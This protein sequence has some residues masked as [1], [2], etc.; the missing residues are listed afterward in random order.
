M[1]INGGAKSA[2]FSFRDSNVPFD[3]G[4]QAEFMLC[5]PQKKG[6]L[7]SPQEAK[8]ADRRMFFAKS[9]SSCSG[10][11][12]NQVQQ[13]SGPRSALLPRHS[14]RSDGKGTRSSSFLALRSRRT[15]S[16]SVLPVRARA[17]CRLY[18]VRLVIF[19]M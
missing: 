19:Q 6:M 7:P 5:S 3:A 18:R 8:Q 9:P 2:L 17:G 15:R 16:C 13:K 14:H 1:G 11:P 12:L 4:Y 10:F